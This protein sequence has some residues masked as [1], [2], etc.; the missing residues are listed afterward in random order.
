[1]LSWILRGLR[2]GVRTT[3]YP[4]RPESQP[5]RAAPQVDPRRI[6]AADCRSLAEV[7][8]TGA[9]ACRETPNEMILTLDYAR[10]IFCGLCAEAVPAVVQMSHDYELASLHREDLVTEF[11]FPGVGHGR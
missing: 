11:V 5:L 4:N 1:M 2:T 9:F 8:P 7:C 10:C 6:R 3:R